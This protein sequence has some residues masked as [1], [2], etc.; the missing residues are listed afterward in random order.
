[1]QRER[2]NFDDQSLVPPFQNNQIEEMDVESDVMDDIVVLFNEIDYYTSHL[3]H[4]E[5]EVAQFSNQCGDQI[6]EEGVIQGQPNNKYDLRTRVG[7][8]KSTT[9]DQTKQV[10][11]PPKPSPN[12]SMSSKTQQLPLSKPAIPKIRESDRSPTSFI[13]E[14][15][16]RKI[17][18]PVPLTKL[19]KNEPFKKSIMKFLQPTPSSVSLVVISQ[20]D[21]NPAIT[22][23]PHIEYGSDSSPPFYISLNVHDKILHN[24]LMDS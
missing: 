3:K 14:H 13:L 1:M 20:Q 11:A 24:C 15:E 6:G 21:E 4:Q 17:K 7:A 18:I 10:E 8:P 2:R 5:Y 23:G 19:L 22:M 12:K 16:L 9:S